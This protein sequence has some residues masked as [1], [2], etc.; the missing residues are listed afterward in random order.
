M[1][2]FQKAQGLYCACV[3][4]LQKY[5]APLVDLALRLWVADAFFRAGL[6]KAHNMDS[7]RALFENEYHVPLLPPDFAAYLGTG[8][9][10]VVPLFLAFG[11]FGRLT[12]GFMFVYNLICVISYPDLWPDGF[13]AD[14]FGDGFTD[15]KVWG[16]MLLVT[17][18]YGPGKLSLD[19]LLVRFFPR[20]RPA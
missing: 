15:H 20:F 11:L 17:L 8:I 3:G 1:K 2:L 10:L 18:V 4:L 12:A 13:W 7:T 14:F 16:L 9:E 6:V 5:L 19:Y